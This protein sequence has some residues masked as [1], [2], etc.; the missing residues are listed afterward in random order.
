MDAISEPNKFAKTILRINNICYIGALVGF[1]AYLFIYI[2][3]N[4]AKEWFA[5]TTGVFLLVAIILTTIRQANLLLGKFSELTGEKVLAMGC[6]MCIAAV[7][8]R[9]VC[10]KDDISFIL[11]TFTITGVSSL[12]LTRS[13]VFAKVKKYSENKLSV[14]IGFYAVVVIVWV[15]Y[16]VLFLESLLK[17]WGCNERI[18][19]NAITL[20]TAIVG[21]GLTLA[22]VAWTIRNT[23]AEHNEE[24]RLNCCPYIS[25]L[26]L[27]NKLMDDIEFEG[28]SSGLMAKTFVNKFRVRLSKNADCIIKGVFVDKQFRLVKNEKI[29]AAE[30]AFNIGTINMKE[31]IKIESVSIV[32]TDI[33]QNWY[34][35]SCKIVQTDA[36]EKDN[37]VYSVKSIGLPVLMSK[38]AVKQ[39]NDSLNTKNN[40]NRG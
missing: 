15:I 29:S 39:L 25:I 2:F 19:D 31:S 27:E 16:T 32:A 13:V 14:I 23:S 17:K 20:L 28:N 22:G 34:E 36:V 9:L 11:Y 30:T 24:L 21:G 38:N 33:L 10:G 8:T 18:I 1:I 35:Y 4:E 12:F 40:T 26:P 3:F 6:V 7:V 5:Y 37:R